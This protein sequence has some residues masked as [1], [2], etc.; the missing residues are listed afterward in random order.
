M[1][2]TGDVYFVA[3]CA[4]LSFVILCIGVTQL[5]RLIEETKELVQDIKHLLHVTRQQIEQIQIQIRPVT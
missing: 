3:V 5:V 4:F 2:S 1:V